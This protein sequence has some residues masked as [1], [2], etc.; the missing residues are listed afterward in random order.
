MADSDDKM[1]P[2]RVALNPRSKRK[3]FSRRAMPAAPATIFSP[4]SLPF[5]GV[6]VICAW[7]SSHNTSRVWSYVMPT[8]DPRSRP[9]VNSIFRGT[10]TIDSPLL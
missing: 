3:Y 7:S 6:I 2:S 9:F 10:R 5:S 8:P 1:R 4:G